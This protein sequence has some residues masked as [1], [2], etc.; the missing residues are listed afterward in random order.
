MSADVTQEY[1]QNQIDKHQMLC[2]RT[3]DARISDMVGA[4]H[5]LLEVSAQLTSRSAALDERTK[6]HGEQINRMEERQSA[7]LRYAIAT[8][9]GIC[10]TFLTLIIGFAFNK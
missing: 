2:T 3:I 6:I 9:I 4:V 7:G 5:S 10:I 8:T 1:V